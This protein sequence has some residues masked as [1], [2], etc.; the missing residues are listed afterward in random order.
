[1]TDN[2]L[3]SLLDPATHYWLANSFTVWGLTLLNLPG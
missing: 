1:M 2:I 3:T